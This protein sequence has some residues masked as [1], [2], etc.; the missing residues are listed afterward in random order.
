MSFLILTP[1]NTEEMEKDYLS[2]KLNQAEKGFDEWIKEKTAS[3]SVEKK[4]ILTEKVEAAKNAVKSTIDKAVTEFNGV[5]KT[6]EQVKGAFPVTKGVIEF[7][8]KQAK[9]IF[10]K[11]VNESWAFLKSQVPLIIPKSHA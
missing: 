8:E 1:L 4:T 2:N 5:M 10:E 9:D 11:V 7:M 3:L 6:V